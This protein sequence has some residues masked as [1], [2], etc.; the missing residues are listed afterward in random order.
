M[1]VWG[2]TLRTD[3]PR[4][5]TRLGPPGSP[6]RG[7]TDLARELRKR[8]KQGWAVHFPGVVVR[9]IKVTRRHAK[10]AKKGKQA[11]AMAKV[12]IPRSDSYNADGTFR[13]TNPAHPHASFDV[14]MRYTPKGYRLLSFSVS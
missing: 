8:R 12:D 4:P 10:G 1:K 2:Y 6:C 5:L 13:N 11:D 7:C 9:T 14:R 3:D